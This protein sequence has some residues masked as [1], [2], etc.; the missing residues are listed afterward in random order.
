[1]LIQVCT[2]VLVLI[3]LCVVVYFANGRKLCFTDFI[4][5]CAITI[6][7]QFVLVFCTIC[8]IW[9]FIWL[10]IWLPIIL[11]YLF[12][13]RTVMEDIKKIISDTENTLTKVK[14]KNDLIDSDMMKTI[15]AVAFEKISEYVRKNGN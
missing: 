4:Q 11:D 3:S 2:F 7:A 1:M 6:F 9:L 15:K 12:L 14:T 5:C 13:R 8:A 10:F